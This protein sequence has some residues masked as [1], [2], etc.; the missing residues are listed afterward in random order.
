MV[1]NSQDVF[2]MFNR[3]EFSKLSEA[4][5]V[6]P[7]FSWGAQHP[8]ALIVFNLRMVLDL[9]LRKTYEVRR[10]YLSWAERIKH[11]PSYNRWLDF[12]AP[13]KFR[14]NR[15]RLLSCFKGYRIICRTKM[16]ANEHRLFC[17]ARGSPN[18]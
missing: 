1:G 7:V 10:L 12:G 14:P 4:V 8:K 9:H 16:L 18:W 11:E 17:R 3:E 6:L 5:L 2:V 13:Y 15:L